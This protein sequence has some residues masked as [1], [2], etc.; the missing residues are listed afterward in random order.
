MRFV[1]DSMAGRVALAL[2]AGV[3]LILGIGII[4]S[5]SDL[6]GE[7]PHVRRSEAASRL[8]SAIDTIRRLPP[9]L[10]PDAARDFAAPD[11]G[12][13]WHHPDAPP[14]AP[15]ANEESRRI[16]WR[17]RRHAP[18]S[19]T[20]SIEAGGLPADV[21]A[22][23]GLPPENVLYVRVRLRDGSWVA[24]Q[25]E[26]NWRHPTRLL[27]LLVTLAVVGTGLALL[28]FWLARWMTAPLGRFATAAERLGADVGAPPMREEGPREIRTAAHAFNDM[29]RRIRRFVDERMHMVAAAAHD[30]RTPITRLKLR[31][32][33]IEDD[34]LRLKFVKD[35]DEMEAVIASTMELAREETAREPSRRFDLGVLLREL[36]AE[37][38]EAGGNVRLACSGSLPVDGRV[39]ALKRA[40]ANL[41]RNA[42]TYGEE[43]NIEVEHR[44]GRAIVRIDDRGPGIPVEE[45]EKVFAPFYTREPSRSRRA[46]GTGLGLSIARAILRSHGGEIELTERPDGKGL[47]QIVSLPLATKGH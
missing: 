6:L 19:A 42:L 17:L 43:A 41:V 31:A 36:A 13:T 24:L 39:V 34:E 25:V 9:D 21:P 46:G 23:A 47:R 12:V 22:V 10:R 38:S 5:T 35:L 11:F 2:I 45:R 40:L 4:V 26:R 37:F 1:P 20:R 33:F 32:E 15:V 18:R 7:P 28:A 29:Q 30:L 8:G 16:E 44:D 27:R 14:A 3:V